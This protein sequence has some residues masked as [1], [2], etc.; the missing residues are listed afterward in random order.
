MWD[1]FQNQ[2]Q[3]DI[4]F[5]RK[6]DLWVKFD[7]IIGNEFGYATHVFGSTINGFGSRSSDMDICVFANSDK[8]RKNLISFLADLRRLLKRKCGDF[9]HPNIELIHAKV[10]ILKMFDQVNR[11]EIDLSCANTEAV[12]NSHLLL[13]YSQ[14]STILTIF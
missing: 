6:I 4:E 3:R 13:W 10:P 7:R 1:L 12:R 5:Q 14:V 9:L 2:C 8:H 11:I